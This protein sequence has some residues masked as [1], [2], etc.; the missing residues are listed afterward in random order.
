MNMTRTKPTREDREFL[1]HLYE[2]VMSLI[3]A[4]ELQEVQ[5]A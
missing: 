5:E 4:G 3:K 2:F 1:D